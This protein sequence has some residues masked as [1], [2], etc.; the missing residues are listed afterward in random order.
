MTTAWVPFCGLRVE[1]LG[2]LFVVYASNNLGTFLRSTRRTRFGHERLKKETYFYC[3]KY[4]S[5][6]TIG[7]FFPLRLFNVV[8]TWNCWNPIHFMRSVFSF[9]RRTK[10]SILNGFHQFESLSFL[11]SPL[12]PTHDPTPQPQITYVSKPNLS[13][14]R[15]R[16]VTTTNVLFHFT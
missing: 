13:T 3:H 16:P 11:L 1:Q 8:P 10:V 15:D 4:T 14:L 9:L 6:L 5:H 7:I 12:S 2:C